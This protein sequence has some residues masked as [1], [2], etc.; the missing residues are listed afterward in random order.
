[1][2]LCSR[3]LATKRADSA[4][5]CDTSAG[6]VG[7][8]H[9]EASIQVV[10]GRGL[11]A[12]TPEQFRVSE[13]NRPGGFDS[14]LVAHVLEHLTK[15]AGGALVSEYIDLVRPGGFLILITPQEAGFRRDAS[16]R[17]FIDFPA[18][19]A[20]CGAVSTFVQREYSFPL[21]RA[22]GKVFFYNEFVVVARKPTE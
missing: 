14:L 7:I 20:F 8:D 11:T 5:K 2:R 22:V 19:R 1:M 3:H 18:L 10:R 13:F 15:E 4:G 21:P 16:H 6:S 12:F 9:N 17:T